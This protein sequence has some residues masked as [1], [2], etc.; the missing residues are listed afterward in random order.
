VRVLLVA[1]RA[2]C[3]FERPKSTLKG[4]SSKALTR[5][6]FLHISVLLGFS[7]EFSLEDT[8][9]KAAQANLKKRQACAAA[10]KNILLRGSLPF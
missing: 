1:A 9:A 3:W 6:A 8:K 5:R 2:T 4:I 10:L 7:S